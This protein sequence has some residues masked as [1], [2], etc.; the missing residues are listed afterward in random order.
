MRPTESR[1]S[2]MFAMLPSAVHSER[3]RKMSFV[4]SKSYIQNSA[5]L[6]AILDTVLLKRLI[7]R[8]K[9]WSRDATEVDL[10]R[11]TQALSMDITSCYLCGL[12]A[13]S[14]FTEDIETRDYYLQA[15]KQ[16]MNA[17]FWH[18]YPQLIR[19]TRRLGIHLVPAIVYESQKVIEKLCSKMCES[20]H[21]RTLE[22]R[23]TNDTKNIQMPDWPVVYAHLR[24]KL[25]ANEPDK[26]KVD[27]LLA[28]EMLDHMIAG[29]DG[30]GNTLSFLIW[31]LS[32][33]PEI[34]NQLRKDFKSIQKNWLL[35]ASRRQLAAP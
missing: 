29:N 28:A 2:F 7:P 6:T 19:W 15:F 4:Y 21:Q 5:A 24:P 10:H 12:H 9:A 20:A 23:H 16:S 13:G 30:A 8:A 34:Q 3:K 1:Q 33:H 27:A 11:E 18:E 31:Q 25:E 14:N 32:K 35:R 17:E 26:S 22:K